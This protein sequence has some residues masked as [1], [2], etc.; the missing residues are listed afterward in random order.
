MSN[1]QIVI[2]FLIGLVFGAGIGVI[3]TSELRFK[4]SENMIR[5]DKVTLDIQDPDSQAF[6]AGCEATF[7]A[8]QAI[9]NDNIAFILLKNCSFQS[10]SDPYK[11]PNPTVDMFPLKEIK[12]IK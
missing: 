10:E 8:S 2:A 5:G 4:H 6:Y 1:R 11:F 3:S 12:R 9:Q 7:I